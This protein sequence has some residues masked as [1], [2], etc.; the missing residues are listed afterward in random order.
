VL[1]GTVHAGHDRGWVDCVVAGTVRDDLY[2]DGIGGF[3]LGIDGIGI[4]LLGHDHEPESVLFFV[5]VWE[6]RA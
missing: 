4:G 3:F 6:R 2:I 5:F 1:G